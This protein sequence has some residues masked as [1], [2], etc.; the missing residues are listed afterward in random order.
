MDLSKSILQ[1]IDK[2]NGLDLYLKRD[3]L[4]HKDV[5]GNKWRKLKEHIRLA[6]ENNID[7]IYSQSIPM[8]VIVKTQD[9]SSL[10]I[11]PWE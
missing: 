6:L 8:Q 9:G 1:K 5:S 7:T 3:D 11:I 2:I 10:R 4:I